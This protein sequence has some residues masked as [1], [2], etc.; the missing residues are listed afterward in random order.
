[1]I[2]QKYID[3]IIDRVDLE[4]VVSSYV[5][6]MKRKGHRS[7]ACCPFHQEKTPSFCVDTAKNL[8]HCY[9]ACQE[10]GNVIKFIE[11]I[12][13]LPFPFAVKKLL[14]DEL[15]ID[16]QDVDI[17]SSPEEEARHK[18][19]EAM[20]IIND[21]LSQW[22]YKQMWEKEDPDVNADR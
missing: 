11:K 10:G 2:D 18:K 22:I 5:G 20:R 17:K 12:E 4:K 21:H 15:H 3:M 16:L 7:W 14:K 19:L 1:M 9:G 13:N 8:W 6:E